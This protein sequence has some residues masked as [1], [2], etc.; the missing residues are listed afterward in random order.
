MRTRA[1][2]CRAVDRP[3]VYCNLRGRLVRGTEAAR[4]R[5][6][7]LREDPSSLPDASLLEDADG[8][9]DKDEERLA[10]YAFAPLAALEA[11]EQGREAADPEATGKP[12]A[13]GDAMSNVIEPPPQV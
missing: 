10:V 3:Q 1:A 2:S 13:R 12:V 11:K 6:P 7:A 5:A 9:S 4:G 8:I